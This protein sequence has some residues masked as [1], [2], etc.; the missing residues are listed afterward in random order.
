MFHCRCSGS[1]VALATPDVHRIITAGA[2]SNGVV[3]GICL[4]M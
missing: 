4:R 2:D 1:V 3:Y